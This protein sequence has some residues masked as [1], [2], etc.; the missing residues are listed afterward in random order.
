MLGN[1]FRSLHWHH[2]STQ[3]DVQDLNSKVPASPLPAP[4]DLPG[5]T[6]CLTTLPLIRGIHLFPQNLLEIVPGA[7][8]SFESG[9]SSYRSDMGAASDHRDRVTSIK[10]RLKY[11]TIGG[12]NGPLVILENVSPRCAGQDNIQLIGGTGQIPEIQ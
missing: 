5:A 2:R 11:N 3:S 6:A 10:P 9:P 7:N 8:S 12:V 4:F 1:D